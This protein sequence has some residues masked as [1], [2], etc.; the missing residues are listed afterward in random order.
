MS[1][2]AY[3]VIVI[4]NYVGKTCRTSIKYQNTND[5]DTFYAQN[6]CLKD[7]VKAIFLCPASVLRM[8]LGLN[9]IK[10]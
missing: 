9:D 6:M 4:A 7:L 3:Q 10:M 1:L 8:F 5:Y 2:F